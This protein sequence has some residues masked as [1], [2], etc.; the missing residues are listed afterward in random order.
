MQENYGIQMDQSIEPLLNFETNW[1]QE[2]DNHKAIFDYFYGD[3]VPDQSLVVAYAKQVPFVED[4]R[5]VIIG[6][7]HVKRIVEAEE[8]KHTDEKP[9]AANV[10]PLNLQKLPFRKLPL[11]AYFPK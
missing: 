3:V 5:R 6:M 7:G 4:H 10:F 9:L 11:L 1:I 2:R 8:H